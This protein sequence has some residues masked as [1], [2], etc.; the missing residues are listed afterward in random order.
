MNEGSNGRNFLK[1]SH[2]SKCQT[3]LIKVLRGCLWGCMVLF[4]TLHSARAQQQVMYTQYMFN[5]IVLNP[6]YAGSHESMS[7]T[8]IARKQWTGMDGA[9]GTETFTA[10]TPLKNDRV[11]LGLIF[12]H[13]HIG[14]THQYNVNIAYSYWIP[15]AGGKLAFG[16]QGGFSNYNNAFA[17]LYV[18][19]QGDIDPNFASNVNV[20]SPTI[21]SG[22]YFYTDKLYLGFSSPQLITYQSHLGETAY[23][24][25]ARHYFLTGGYVFDI[26]PSLKYKPGF[27]LKMVEG[28]PAQFDINSHLLFREVLW[29]GVSYRSMESMSALLQV[30]LTDQLRF[31]YSYDFPMGRTLSRVNSGSHEL[32]LNYSFTFYK[33]GYVSPRYF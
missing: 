24:R 28:A 18:G 7:L 11:G 33:S 27:L 32:M 22:L 9:P 16:L 19:A 13:D 4:I 6:A 29:T 5:G 12:S 14:V 31:G 3:F 21:G 8:A 15:V 23:T 10:H 30:Q 25:Q 1:T 20:F 26:T 2:F 17:D